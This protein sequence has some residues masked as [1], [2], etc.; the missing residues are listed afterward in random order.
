M[1]EEQRE[2]EHKQQMEKEQ[3]EVDDL[4]SKG[5]CVIETF[6]SHKYTTT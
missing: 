1:D 6:S 3:M 2:Y 4:Q 5:W